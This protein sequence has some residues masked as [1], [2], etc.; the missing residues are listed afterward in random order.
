MAY[1]D[2][3]VDGFCK[4]AQGWENFL[5]IKR[6]TYHNID[7]VFQCKD[8]LDRNRKEPMSEKKLWKEMTFG[9]LRR[10]Y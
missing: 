8:S 3:F 5:R 7:R 9:P 6:Q 1:I 2:V 4:L 10:S